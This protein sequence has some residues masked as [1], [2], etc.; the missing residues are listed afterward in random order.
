MST[1]HNSLCGNTARAIS[2]CKR[3]GSLQDLPAIATLVPLVSPK[4]GLH[5]QI[6]LFFT[7]KLGRLQLQ[8]DT[9][10]QTHIVDPS[11]CFSL[12]LRS[13]FFPITCVQ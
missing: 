5:R 1:H 6:T 7:F 11:I 3:T 4:H 9:L 10:I 13:S 2:A 12:K 8:I